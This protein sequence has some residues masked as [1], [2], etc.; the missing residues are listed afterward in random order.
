MSA[1]LPQVESLYIL[2]GVIVPL[3]F[4]TRYSLMPHRHN[5]KWRGSRDTWDYIIGGFC[6]RAKSLR[7]AV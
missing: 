2:N 7:D 6:G 1:I 5:N 3:T 4:L